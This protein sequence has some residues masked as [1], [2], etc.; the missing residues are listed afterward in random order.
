VAG[1][2]IGSQAMTELFGSGFLVE[3]T[4]W[5]VGVVAGIILAVG[6]YFFWYIAV[7]ALFGAVGFWLGDAVMTAITPDAGLLI[8]IV[9]LVVGVAF[10]L[11]A[12]ALRFPKWAVLAITA[13]G[14]A[15]VAVSGLLLILGTITIEA[16]QDG[17][18]T[19]AW[20]AGPIWAL[21]TLAV[22]V[23][24]F[25][26]QDRSTKDFELDMTRYRDY[27]PSTV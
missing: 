22:A 16:M 26:A 4:S 12:I 20:N 11:G 8:F 15:G 17:P 13:I 7:V 14:G 3:V 19:A 9:G 25:F 6:S 23:A 2:W 24:G 5:V 10:V 18:F 21:I 27:S 1:F